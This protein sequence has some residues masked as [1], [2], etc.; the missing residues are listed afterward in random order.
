MY[1]PLCSS[2][3][4]KKTVIKMHLLHLHNEISMNYFGRFLSG[5]LCERYALLEI[6]F[7]LLN[8][9]DKKESDWSSNYSF[10][11]SPFRFF[12]ASNHENKSFFRVWGFFSKLILLRFKF[13]WNV[14][15][16]G[17]WC[18]HW[19]IARQNNCLNDY[20]CRFFLGLLTLSSRLYELNSWSKLL[21]IFSVLQK[22]FAKL[23]QSA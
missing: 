22:K 7:S 15:Y 4:N 13:P 14:R 8:F 2:G 21:V 16:L 18:F 3:G 10:A 1:T 12:S 6:V 20:L 9:C 5:W 11:R 23:V 19:K 17:W